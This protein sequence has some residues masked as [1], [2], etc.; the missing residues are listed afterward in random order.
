MCITLKPA[1]PVSNGF[2]PTVY[3]KLYWPVP[4]FRSVSAFICRTLI[5]NVNIKSKRFQKVANFPTSVSD[6]C[7]FL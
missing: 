1:V 5:P 2:L 3:F 7:Y 4:P 6:D